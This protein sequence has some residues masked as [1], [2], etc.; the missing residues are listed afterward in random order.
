MSTSRHNRQEGQVM[1]VR[2][3]RALRYL[4]VSTPSQVHTD[5]NPEGISIPAQ[6]EATDRKAA[7]LGA[8]I[9]GEYIE[10]GRTA[11][12]IAKR[13][14]F[15]EMLTRI[16]AERDVDY[17][18]VYHF[19]RIF[20]NSVDAAIVKRDLRKLGVR[21]VSSVMD[22]GDSPESAMVESII[23]AVD[24][25]QSEASG[26]DISYK[27][28]EKAKK[29]G[30]LHRAPIGYR[31][32]IIEVDGR[33]VR[34]VEVDPERAPFIVK[35]FELFATGQ[36]SGQ[37]VLDLM[38]EAGLRTRGDKR[39]SPKPVSLS[40]LYDILGN[41]YYAGFVTYNGEEYKG[42]H[43][44]LVTPELFDRVQRVLALRG[45]AGTRQ[46]RHNH[47]LKGL[48]WCGR[49]GER[50][51]ISPGRG[52]GGTYFYYVCRGRQKRTCDQ[53]YLRVHELD[54]NVVRHYASV[55]LSEAFRAKLRRQLDDVLLDELG[56]LD[57]LR[58]R[59]KLRLEQLDAKEEQYLDLVGEPGWPREKL[60]QRLDAIAAERTTI[61]DQLA[62]TASKLETGREFFLSAL[63]LLSN[64]QAFY[65]RGGTSLRRA[66]NTVIFGK[67]YVTDGE[68]TAHEL[69]D[70][71]ETLVEADRASRTYYRRSEALSGADRDEYKKSSLPEERAFLD[72]L[73]GAGLLTVALGANGSS[74]TALVELTGLEPVTPALPVRC[75]TSCATAPETI[76][77]VLSRRVSYRTRDR[78]RP[79]QQD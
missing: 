46:R 37:Q 64:P 63:K 17:V 42:R 72:R 7:E 45:G 53:P 18:I 5:Y 24:Q 39:F 31:N 56:S 79:P 4:R 38:T 55:Q 48:L 71:A 60:R 16:K 9:V 34:T 33:T 40:Q 32:V 15:Q 68:I 69:T 59:L 75:A 65:K 36:Y 52:N 41:R 26:A 11:T 47:Y 10:P 12:S 43:D 23:H 14:T 8:E 78:Q 28:G 51:I 62:G 57:A 27:M 1:T 22:L 2:G 13:P 61:L 73:T 20:R 3:K 70:M 30:T 6:R 67:L 21:I 77:A 44:A 35:G 54:N 66:M 19:N 58:K 29:G 49:C 74:R 50:L 76:T 25:Y